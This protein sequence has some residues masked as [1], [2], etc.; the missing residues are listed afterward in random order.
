MK[1]V[2][3]IMNLSLICR[4][5]ST[6]SNYNSRMGIGKSLILQPIYYQQI[7]KFKFVNRSI[8]AQWNFMKYLLS[9]LILA[10][11]SPEELTSIFSIGSSCSWWPTTPRNLKLNNFINKVK[12]ILLRYLFS[13]S[14]CV[15]SFKYH[16][17]WQGSG[18]A[19]NPSQCS[20][21]L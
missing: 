14:K 11:I 16:I 20:P 7:C 1:I 8:T 21:V 6:P 5:P 13:N 10:I 2:L 18:K 19:T 9:W 15:G 12:K 4:K 17:L 3:N